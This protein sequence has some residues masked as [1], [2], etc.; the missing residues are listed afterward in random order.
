MSMVSTPPPKLA[1]G[2]PDNKLNSHFCSPVRPPVDQGP[3]AG[4]TKPGPDMLRNSP[5]A[6]AVNRGS[7]AG[8][9]GPLQ[10]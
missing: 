3:H 5:T 8:E 1:L 7:H 10:L 6:S 2:G 9:A 4:R